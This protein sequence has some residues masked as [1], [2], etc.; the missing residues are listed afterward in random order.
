[1][2]IIEKNKNRVAPNPFTPQSGWEPKVFGGREEILNR[3]EATLKEAKEVRP[4]HLVV[5]GDWG[6]GKTSLLKQFKKSAQKEGSPASFCA[7]NRFPEK[8]RV[9]EGIALLMEEI[10]LGFPNVPEGRTFL[11]AGEKKLARQPQVALVQFLVD[12]WGLLHTELALVLLDDIQN[13]EAIPQVIDILRAALSHDSVLDKSRYLFILATTPEGWGSFLDKHDPVGRFF[14]KRESI[15]NLDREACFA[16]VGKTLQESGVSFDP[17]IME[18]LY[19]ITSGHPY[20]VQLLASHLYDAQIEGKVGLSSWEGAFER[21][22]RELG[23]DYFDALL[24]RASDRENEILKVLAE[25]KVPMSIA[26]L[27]H[28][29]IFEKRKRNFPVD[30]IKNYLYRL[31]AKGLIRRKEDVFSILDPMVGEFILRISP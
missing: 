5:L 29:M 6:M 24:R 12:L 27:R 8:S 1:M 9:E 25:K 7:I 11:S 20:E 2:E 15:Q 19:A 22:L 17:D 10:I 23:Q 31:Q 3:F 16:L 18:K 14:R 13:F 21:T 28:A 26:E 4:H 30:D